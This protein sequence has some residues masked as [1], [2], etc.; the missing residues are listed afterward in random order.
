MTT[1]GGGRTFN[2]FS[3][4]LGAGMMTLKRE[5]IPTQIYWREE[6]QMM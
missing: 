4:N 5:E 2:V 3:S 1:K 6:G